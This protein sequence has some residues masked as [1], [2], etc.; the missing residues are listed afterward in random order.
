MRLNGKSAPNVM[1]LVLYGKICTCLLALIEQKQ[2]L[3]DFVPAISV[4]VGNGLGGK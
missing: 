4:R 2:R 3:M 1:E